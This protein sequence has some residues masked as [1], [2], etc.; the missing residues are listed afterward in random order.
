MCFLL[1]T[2]TWQ[3]GERLSLLARPELDCP[4][5]QQHFTTVAVAQSNTRGGVDRDLFARA[6]G[7]Q[8]VF[9]RISTCPSCGY[10]G[11]P[12]DFDPSIHISQNVRQRILEEPGLELPHGFTPQ[13]EPRDLGAPERYALAIQ[14]YRWRDRSH[15]A[16]AWLHL[17]ASWVQRDLG[18]MLP[19]DE[20]IALVFAFI[21]RWRPPMRPEQNQRDIE[22]Q[23]VTRVAEALEFGRFSRYQKPYVELVLALLLRRHG[24]NLQ[25]EALLERLEKIESFDEPVRH[26]MADMMETMQRERDHQE[27][28]LR[29]F[30]QALKLDEIKNENRA[31]ATYL[32]GELHRRLG[33]DQEARHWF[34]QAVKD[35]QL[36]DH[37]RRWAE[38][39]LHADP[40][41]PAA[42]RTA[43]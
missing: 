16:L 7:P 27:N 18:A 5:C 32:V 17:R 1:L 30:E 13:S 29:H 31:V 33:R 35:T 12:H 20:R 40:P 11:Y 4:V 43:S 26:A 25:A 22:M 28:A 23:L 24:E 38:S 37:V 34:R 19:P 36:P 42:Q 3:E 14:C 8:P 2:G 6:L 9:F 41:R 15:E 21:E 39:L 10:S